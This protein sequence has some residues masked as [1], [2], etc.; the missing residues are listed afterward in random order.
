MDVQKVINRAGAG[1]MK[2][3]MRCALNVDV[4]Q[5]TALPAGAKILAANHP[6]T[7]DP[8]YLLPLVQEPVYLLITEMAFKDPVLGPMLPISGHMKVERDHGRA[9]F[10]QAVQR[11]RAGATVGIFPEGSLSPRD[12][13]L[14][15]LKTGTVRLALEAGVP[16]IP[17]G[18]ALDASRIRYVDMACGDMSQTARWYLHGPYAIT[19]GEPLVFT[20][21]VEDHEYVRAMSGDLAV[22]IAHLCVESAARLTAAGMVSVPVAASRALAPV[23]IP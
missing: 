4:A 14:C 12:G 17:I 1:L 15:R 21:S 2:S 7:S 18:I 11:L 10:D 16:V 23:S 19:V 9:A 22:R 3:Y 5:H 13:G 8:F 20:G 6:T